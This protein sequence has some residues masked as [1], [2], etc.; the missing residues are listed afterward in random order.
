[1]DLGFNGDFRYL[2]AFLYVLGFDHIVKAPEVPLAFDQMETVGCASYLQIRVNKGSLYDFV[3]IEKRLQLLD[4]VFF[5]ILGL[6]D[7]GKE[8]GFLQIVHLFHF[9]EFFVQPFAVYSVQRHRQ[10]ESAFEHIFVFCRSVDHLLFHPWI[11]VW[12]T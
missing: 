3:L 2:K 11:L 4:V 5:Q 10:L 7:Q 8:F 6:I 12:F 9:V 1:V